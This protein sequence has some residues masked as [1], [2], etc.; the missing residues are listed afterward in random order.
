MALPLPPGLTPP[1]VAFLCEME[2]VSIIPR[3]RLD[4]LDLLGGSI[5]ALVPPHKTSVPLWLALLLKRQRRANIVPP[6]WL[7]PPWLTA[8]LEYETEHPDTF[9][10][11][12]RLPPA[13]GDHS[14][15]FSPPF[16]PQSTVEAG[17]D[18]LPYH[19]LELGEML[20]EAATDD[21]EDGESVR[22]LLQGLR[23]VRMA[24]LRKRTETLDEPGGIRMNG[25]GGME[26]AEGRSFI[27]GVVDGLRRIRA[28]YEEK[29][30]E[31]GTEDGAGSPRTVDDYD[32][33]EMETQLTS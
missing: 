18:A 3:Q 27:T 11:P 2:L 4:S 29:R 30:R 19:W 9:S 7:A 23:E 17:P 8:I 31:R 20:L 21:F 15:V 16:L 12:P 5:P 10:P 26:V 33:D 25:I 32:D 24:K 28:T 1:E 13:P 22:R 14:I 6:P